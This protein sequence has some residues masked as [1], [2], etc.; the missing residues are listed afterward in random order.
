MCWR[1]KGAICWTVADY[2]ERWYPVKVRIVGGR[3]WRYRVFDLIRMESLHDI[4]W[5][6]LRR[7]L[8]AARTIARR[9]N[10][11]RIGK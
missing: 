10:T 4:P 2:W 6:R 7:S 1:R 11:R 3:L 8:K 9:M 5:Y